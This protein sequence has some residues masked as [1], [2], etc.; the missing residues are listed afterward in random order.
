[1]LHFSVPTMTKSIRPS[2]EHSHASPESTV[3]LSRSLV[4]QI[5]RPAGSPYI[6]WQCSRQRKITVGYSRCRS[7]RLHED[8]DTQ[9]PL[10]SVNIALSSLTSCR[11]ALLPLGC[12]RWHATETKVLGC[13]SRRSSSIWLREPQLSK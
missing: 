13:N 9:K 5:T 8:N 10:L 12:P 1:M 11:S 2:G 6:L 4:L 7:P 3:S